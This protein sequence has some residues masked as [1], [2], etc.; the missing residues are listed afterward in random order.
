MAIA[1]IENR[2]ITSFDVQGGF[3][4][5]DDGK[6]GLLWRSLLWQRANDPLHR[7]RFDLTVVAPPSWSWMAYKGAI[8]YLDLPF[9]KVE[10]EEDDIQAQWS[11]ARM[12]SYS[13]DYSKCPL[14]L[15]VYPR[16][17][18]L[19]AAKTCDDA[20]ILLDNPDREAELEPSLK[21]VVIGKSKD[22]DQERTEDR[23][24]YIMLLAST[25]VQ[26]VGTHCAT[27]YSR[28]GVGYVP[29]VL[30]DYNQPVERGELR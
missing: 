29:G 13:R 25:A 15:N 14:Q 9:N 6:R 18:D 7:I 17:F 3:G 30:I 11:I 28:V 8:D 4:V 19:K 26:E 21:C 2:L 22:E 16:G 10:W 24:H 5:L 12:W 1:G 23:T 20:R 27:V